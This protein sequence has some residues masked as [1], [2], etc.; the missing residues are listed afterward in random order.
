M[1]PIPI[2]TA[3]LTVA[4][5]FI[6]VFQ[7]EALRD[8]VGLGT[9]ATTVESDGEP[10]PADRDADAVDPVAVVA[11]T[12]QAQ[13]IDTGVLVR[14]E[15]QAMRSVT[16]VSE[17]TGRVS[18][19]PVAKGRTVAEGDILCE[20]DP[21]TREI[22]VVQAE[23]QVAEARKNLM[24]AESLSVDGFASETRVLSARSAFESAQAGLEQAKAAL[25]DTK[26]T[27]P[28]AGII[29]GDVPEIGTLLQPG[30][31]CAQIVQLDPMKLVGNV[32]EASV[33]RIDTGAQVGARLATGEQMIGQLSFIGRSAD[34][35]TRTF[36]VEAEVPNPDLAIRAG[37][38]VEMLIA[39]TGQ[40][41]HLVPQ[42]ALTLNDAGDLGIRTAG[43]DDVATFMPVDLVRDSTDGVWVTGLPETV[44]VI[45]VG[46][47]YVKD[48][49]PISVE[50]RE[51]GT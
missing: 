18:A 12:S 43:E 9:P 13:D 34:P 16:L 41:A 8:F 45:V 50:Y 1:R 35:V 19:P 32:A 4:I 46:Q 20:L 28:F 48:G 36:R 30:G 33:S 31:V 47:D 17:T 25:E 27:A 39:S 26:I 23:A 44:D 38:A 14:G 49:V 10:A 21:G 24:A 11:M 37:Q 7:R 5:L 22:S 40:R 6:M 51:S 42:S 29:E 2:I 15:T 3:L